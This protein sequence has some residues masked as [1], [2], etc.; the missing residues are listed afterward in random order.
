MV[1]DAR[2]PQEAADFLTSLQAH[3]AWEFW[4]DEVRVA[5]SLGGVRGYRQV[6][7]AHLLTLATDHDGVVAT[8]NAALGKLA[9]ERGQKALVIPWV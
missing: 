8:F 2:T 5:R 3:G 4:S 1:V 9:A 7:D 6:T